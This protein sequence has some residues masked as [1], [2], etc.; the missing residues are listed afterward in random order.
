[1]SKPDPRK[2]LGKG[3]HSL[4]PQR[5]APQAAPAPP[6]PPVPEPPV[7]GSVLVVPIEQVAPNPNQ[8]RREF[9]ESALLE[10]S[11][12]IEREGVIQP[13]LVRRVGPDQFQIIAGERRWRASGIAG[14]KEIPVIPREATDEQVLEL[15]IVENI[16]REDLNPMELALAFQR[17]A[18]ELNLSHEQIGERT[19][20]DRA[21][22][23]NTM[24]L[25]QLPEK[26]RD[27]VAA[28]KLTPGHARALLKLPTP[29]VQETLA[30]Q[31]VRQGWS[32]RQIEN[33]T[34]LPGD[35]GSGGPKAPVPPPIVD[36]NVKAAVAQMEQALGTRV[37]IVEKGRSSP[38]QS[39]GH[40]EI[41][42]YN[43]VDLERIYEM[44]V[45]ETNE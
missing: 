26:I 2:A 38:G 33:F 17:M 12:S 4:L 40:I 19:G 16:Q 37:R 45:G 21:T 42:Y 6:P 3:L 1:M 34:K 39:Q 18:T 7:E 13:I 20:K 29:E 32:V 36:P 30:N 31:I 10:L 5:P 35:K 28:K 44:I 25:L 11:Q 15:A 23:T 22:V 27:M 9:D 8:P 43:D 41:E 24:R 14:L